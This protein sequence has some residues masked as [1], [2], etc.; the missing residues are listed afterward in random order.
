MR[1]KTEPSQTAVSP[2]RIRK[3]QVG[4]GVKPEQI[5]TGTGSVV[6]L[7]KCPERLDQVPFPVRRQDVLQCC[8]CCRLRRSHR[9][10]GRQDL[11]LDTKVQHKLPRALTLAPRLTTPEN[12]LLAL[13]AILVP[14]D[15]MILA[16]AEAPERAL[17]AT[18]A[19]PARNAARSGGW[20]AALT[21]SADFPDSEV[22]AETPP[23]VFRTAVAR[24][25]SSTTVPGMAAR[26]AIDIARARTW[27]HDQPLTR[28]LLA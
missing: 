3:H 27:P 2:C 5:N 16:V 24:A 6:G 1:S 23:T 14:A 9:C 20:A 15:V 12:L 13:T 8:P 4:D 25:S 7:N 28:G 11:T 17:A 18:L 26:D 19:T 22:R 10:R 21:D